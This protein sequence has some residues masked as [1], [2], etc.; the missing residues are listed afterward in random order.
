VNG[1]GAAVAARARA[2]VGVRFR[3]QGRRPDS[4]FD[5]VGLAAAAAEVAADR[6]PA[7]YDLRGQDL[8]RI[9]HALCDLGCVPVPGS[10]PQAGDVVIC[11][12][13]P[14]HFH[15]LVATG[16]G[17]VHADAGLRRVVERPA[18]LPW[19]AVGVWRL[20]GDE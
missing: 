2:F 3:P 17:F 13:G 7:D 16:Q 5:C 11:A 20:A 18:P 12:V 6:L 15:I 19:P 10:A 8:V 1:R 9:E 14:A 4:G